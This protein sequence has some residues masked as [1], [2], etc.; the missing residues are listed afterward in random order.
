MKLARLWQQPCLPRVTL[1]LHP[2]TLLLLGSVYTP[3]T[4][5][6]GAEVSRRLLET[7]R[8]FSF[9]TFTSITFSLVVVS[10]LKPKFGCLYLYFSFGDR[11]VKIENHVTPLLPPSSPHTFDQRCPSCF[12]SQAEREVGNLTPY[13]QSLLLPTWCYCGWRVFLSSEP[14]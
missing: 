7:S 4:F 8:T 3:K 6:W 9:L 13:Q 11:A 14:P 5:L 2:E 1:P 12:Q 10:R